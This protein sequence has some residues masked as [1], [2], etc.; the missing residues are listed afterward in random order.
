MSSETV[1][2]CQWRSLNTTA[3]LI[4]L[5]KRLSA[6]EENNTQIQSHMT[7]KYVKPYVTLL[8][9]SVFVSECEMLLNDA[10]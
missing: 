2:N 8:A 4:K 5:V 9:F 10:L 3:H 1:F 6:R 7:M